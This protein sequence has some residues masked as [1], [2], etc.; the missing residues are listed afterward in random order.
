MFKDYLG[1]Y[2]RTGP[3]RFYCLTVLACAVVLLVVALTTQT[4]GRTIFGSNLGADF[5]QF[6]IA[7]TILNQ[8]STARLYD[9]ALQQHLYHEM[10]PDEPAD[11][12]LP[13]FY[14]PYFAFPF[15][16]LSR[17][18]YSAA[19]LVWL[20]ISLLLYLAGLVL[21]SRTLEFIPIGVLRTVWLLALAFMPFL[22]EC[23][24]GGQVSVWAF[25]AL[26]LVLRCE[27]LG[28]HFLSGLA[29]ALC[30]YKPTLLFLVG[31]MLVVTRRWKTLLGF[32]IGGLSLA[33]AS[34]LILGWRPN[35][36]Y[37]DAI[38]AYARAVGSGEVWLR[39]W[40]Y[41]D[42]NSNLRLLV[43]YDSLRWL[44][45][46]A[47]MGTGLALL[48]RVAW[49]LWRSRGHEWDLTWA[50]TL[51]WTLVL[52]IYMPIYDTILVVPS[53]LLTT[54]A[55]SRRSKD[56]GTIWTPA[57]QVLLGLIHLVPWFTQAIARTTGFQ[58]YTVVLATLGLFQLTLVRSS[59]TTVK[60]Q[61]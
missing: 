4:R 2:L 23:W 42:L 55:L 44:L 57:F 37:V 60:A 10:F 56:F 32:A 27:R 33:I 15:A 30:S 29:L 7:G 36:D 6:Y 9:F 43:G 12:Q 35:L 46:L 48:G 50:L 54:N 16:V 11:S 58:S 40:K 19:F 13:Y 51:T 34:I 25:F 61:E 41:I 38:V 59:V 17:L 39:L 20:L 24:L 5:A 47:V 52:N 22:F 14:P 45:T 1:R 31:P 21:L 18:P 8:Y 26:A 49:Q 28:S 3:I 53:V